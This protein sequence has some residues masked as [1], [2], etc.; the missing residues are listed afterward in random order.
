MEESHNF[1]FHSMKNNCSILTLRPSISKD[2]SILF[3]SRTRSSVAHHYIKEKIKVQHR[4]V[5]S[6]ELHKTPNYDQALVKG[7]V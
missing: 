6:P 1:A 7:F 2:M 3:F 4:P 5:L